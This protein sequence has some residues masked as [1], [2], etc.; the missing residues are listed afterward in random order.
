M[1]NFVKLYGG[2]STFAVVR[3]YYRLYKIS[4]IFDATLTNLQYKP[5]YNPVSL[6]GT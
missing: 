2:C 4:D 6:M 3:F 5:P 1:L